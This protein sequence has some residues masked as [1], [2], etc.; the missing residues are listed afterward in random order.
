MQ[1]LRAFVLGID[2]E[3]NGAYARKAEPEIE[4]LEPVTQ[5]HADARTA[6]RAEREKRVGDPVRARVRFAVAH[7]RVA[8][9]D[10]WPRATRVRSA[11]Q[12]TRSDLVSERKAFGHHGRR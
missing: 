8:A 7:D 9:D 3:L 10:E 2:R 6:R 5:Q 1:D 4:V 11:L 12:N